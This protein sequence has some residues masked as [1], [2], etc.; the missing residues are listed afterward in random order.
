[1][2]IVS[3]Y[4]LLASSKGFFLETLVQTKNENYDSEHRRYF[5]TVT[6]LSEVMDGSMRT[7]FEYRFDGQDLLAEDN[8]R[9]ETVFIEA[10]EA[11]AKMPPELGFELRRRRIEYE[12]YGDMLGMAIGYLP[13]TM[14]VVSDFPPELMETN[15]NAGGYNVHRKQTM[16]RVIKRTEDGKLQMRSQSLDLSDRFALEKLYN[17][18]GFVPQEG[19][20]LGQRMH[21]E[22][23]DHEQDFLIDRLM[24][25]YDRTLSLQYG[26]E[27]YAGQ[28]NGRKLNTYDFVCAQTDLLETYFYYGGI[29]RNDRLTRELA[30]AMKLRFE[31]RGNNMHISE[32]QL[33][34]VSMKQVRLEMFSAGHVADQERTSFNGCGMSSKASE[35]KNAEQQNSELGYGNKADKSDS[36]K[37]IWKDGVC[38]ID[39]CPTRPGK[40]KV[41][42]CSVCRGCQALFDKGRDPSKL[43]KKFRPVQKH[44][45]ANAFGNWNVLKGEGK[46]V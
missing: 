40:T 30:A 13:N 16:L 11:A 43:Y 27:W 22:L 18:L 3:V 34:P 36:E 25:A 31:G 20:L 33:N 10:I 24:G 15:T 35:S 7:P 32:V 26:G 29:L 46:V 45:V 21:L 14:V 8:S 37:L 42:Q 1:M 4:P 2:P 9:M 12:E 5:D 28:L 39:N 23:N 38:R 17:T 19:E 6:W 41:A 44:A